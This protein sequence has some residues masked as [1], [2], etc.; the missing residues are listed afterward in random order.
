[1][2]VKVQYGNVYGSKITH[3]MLRLIIGVEAAL[4]IRYFMELH[5]LTDAIRFFEKRSVFD[6]VVHYQLPIRTSLCDIA[7]S[8]VGRCL[9]LHLCIW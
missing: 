7:L 3:R 2:H 1:M 9:E 5:A 6:S 4:Y 8:D